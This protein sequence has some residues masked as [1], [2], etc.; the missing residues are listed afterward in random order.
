MSSCSCST[1]V[2]LAIAAV[3]PG[4]AIAW[5]IARPGMTAPIASATSV[6]QLQELMGAARLEL[7]PDTIA[8]LDAA[9]A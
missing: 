6:G 1:D 5:L 2:A 7:D 8:L 9:S 3:R 4:R